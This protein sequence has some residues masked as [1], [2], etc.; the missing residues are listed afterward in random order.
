LVRS[1]IRW[2]SRE[3]EAFNDWLKENDLP[4]EV[5]QKILAAKVPQQRGLRNA[6]P[7]PAAARRP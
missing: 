4:E 2:R 5:E 3:P 6:R 1:G 7:R